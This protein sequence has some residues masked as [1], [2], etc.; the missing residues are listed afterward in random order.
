MEGGVTVTHAPTPLLRTH[1]RVRHRETDVVPLEAARLGR[2][3]L[4]QRCHTHAGGAV[5]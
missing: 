4:K 2:S 5:L 1:K 3:L